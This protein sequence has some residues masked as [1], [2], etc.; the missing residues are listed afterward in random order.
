MKSNWSAATTISRNWLDCI[1]SR[2]RPVMDV[3]TG[4]RVTCWSHL[5]NIA[6]RLRRK[7]QWDPAAERFVG[8]DEA[9]LLLHVAYR[10]PWRL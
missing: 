7:L 10:E 4:H 3:E 6:Y 5:G 8:D 9:N 1:A 2:R